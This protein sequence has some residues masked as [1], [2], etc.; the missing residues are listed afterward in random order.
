MVGV[1]ATITLP[2]PQTGRNVNDSQFDNNNGGSVFNVQK[3][4]RLQQ[5]SYEG[6]I[7]RNYNAM[8]DDTDTNIPI[9]QN[10]DN[11]EDEK[12]NNDDLNEE[13]E[14]FFY[15]QGQQHANSGQFNNR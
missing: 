12:V 14:S 10:I 11:E 15:S 4:A 7:G 1:S 6:D 5:P 3:R 2:G 8:I 13:V 9:D